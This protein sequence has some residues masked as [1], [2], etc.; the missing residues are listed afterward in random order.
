MN[1]SANVNSRVAIGSSATGA[2]GR[3]IEVRFPSLLN[4]ARPRLVNVILIIAL[5]LSAF[6]VI[7]IKD[8]NRR[9]FIEYQDLQATHNKLYEDWGKLLLEQSTWSTQAR[10]KKIAQNRLN[11]GTPTA[12]DVIILRT[13]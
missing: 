1:T 11:M 8:L 3:D 9:T 12:N 10:V 2:Y 6:C 5:V 4:L 13:S 7:Y